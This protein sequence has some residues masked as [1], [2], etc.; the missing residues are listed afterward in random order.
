MPSPNNR[1]KLT[2]DTHLPDV[3]DEGPGDDNVLAF[4][5]VESEEGASGGEAS[6]AP[7]EGSRGAYMDKVRE[8]VRQRPV[9]ALAGA[10]VLGLL[11]AR[12]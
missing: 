4:E 2:G 6:A 5:P 8:Q 9:A 7:Y 12:I 1:L 10:F 11:L 3:G